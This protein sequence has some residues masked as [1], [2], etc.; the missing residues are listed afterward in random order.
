MSDGPSFVGL[1]RLLLK[2]AAFTVGGGTVTM[3]ALERDLVDDLKWMTRDRF[4]ALYGLARITPGTNILALVTGIGWD[5]HRW[6]GA[7]MALACAA[8]P[9][10]ILATLLAAGYEQAYRNPIVQRFLLGAAAAVCGFIA[11]SVWKLLSPYLWG[12]RR[13]ITIVVFAVGLAVSLL[14]V[15]PFPVIVALAVA[16]YVSAR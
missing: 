11:A 12:E 9:G 7:L 15:S 8:I 1:S 10:A 4:R 14:G 6:P 13:G 3:V 5:F 16:G 2:H